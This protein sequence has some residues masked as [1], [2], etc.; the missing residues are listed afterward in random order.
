MGYVKEALRR[1]AAE[2][3]A[4]LTAMGARLESR[5]EALEKARVAEVEELRAE[6]SQREVQQAAA[7]KEELT[8]LK[9]RRIQTL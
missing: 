8:R 2:Q 9:V 6:L 4:A 7:H 5:G 3:Q 1:R